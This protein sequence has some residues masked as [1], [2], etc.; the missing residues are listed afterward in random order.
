MSDISRCVVPDCCRFRN[1]CR[2]ADHTN[3]VSWQSWIS[4]AYDKETESCNEYIRGN[5]NVPKMRKHIN[6]EE[7]LV[8]PPYIRSGL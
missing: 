8:P 4:G 6:W 5:T 3:I 7:F 1:H 2:R